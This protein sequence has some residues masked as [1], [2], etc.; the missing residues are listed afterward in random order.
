MSRGCSVMV[1]TI[2]RHRFGERP[3][4]STTTTSDHEPVVGIEHFLNDRSLPLVDLDVGQVALDELVDRHASI[5]MRSSTY[6]Q[7]ATHIWSFSHWPKRSGG[8]NARAPG[9][10]SSCPQRLHLGAMLT[11]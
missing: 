4:S 5:L 2:L 11:R 3:V 7:Q 9:K 8:V 6:G 1:G 10:L